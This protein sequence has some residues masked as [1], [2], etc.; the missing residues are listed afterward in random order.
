MRESAE[1]MLVLCAIIAL[2]LTLGKFSWKGISLGTSAVIFVALLAGHFGFDVP[3]FA[4]AA[5][6]AL[7]VYCLGVGA[8]PSFLRMFAEQGRRLAILAVVMLTS[9]SIV[10]VLAGRWLALSPDLT[11]GLFAGSLTSTPALAATAQRLPPES[12]V[13]VGFGVAYPFG[14][15]GVILFVQLVPR[16]TTKQ[17]PEDT[18]DAA[19]TNGISRVLIRV[20]NPSVSGKNLRDVKTISRCN[21]QV[22]RWMIDGA[23]RPI[24]ADFRLELD[25]QLLVI[26]ERQRL[27]EVID[28][29]GEPCEDANYVLDIERHRRRI[30]V[31]SPEV[32]GRSLQDLH[33]RSKFGVT[34]ARI[35]RQDVEFVPSAVERIQLGDALTAVG[36]EAGLDR[37]VEFAGHRERTAEETDLICL[38]TGLMLG[39]LLGR[40]EFVFE[41]ESISL[42][43]AGGSL[44]VGLI[45]GHFQR[46]GPFT[47][48]FP[49]PAR[50]LL[51][52]LGISMFLAHAGTQAGSN[53]LSVLG[54]HGWGLPLAAIAI[55]TVPLAAGFAVARYALGLGTYESCGGICGAMTSTPGLGVVMSSV[56]DSRPA[57]SYATVY[58]LALVLVTLIAPLLIA[59][60]T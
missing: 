53:F 43:L 30:V 34:V 2:G 23:L 17:Q 3:S 13:A 49:R 50:L 25:Q 32:V 37:F 15:I 42:G 40:V 57:T 1:E 28:L 59:W 7:F 14:V 55:V 24:P 16:L 8:G 26:G 9:A 36:E 18:S 21:C 5:G 6:V 51:A 56:D 48:R 27:Q 39:I 60:M 12:D 20:V 29:L 38:A 22:S 54:Q 46:V 45:L 33:L 10:A 44:V 35:T 4:G 47:N 19:R 52:D 58:P 11:S 31:T 41:G